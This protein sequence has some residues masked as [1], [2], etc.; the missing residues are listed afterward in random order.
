MKHI[1]NYNTEIHY[2]NKKSLNK[3]DY[4]NFYNDNFNF[5]KIED[6][7][8]SPQTCVTNNITN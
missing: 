5:S 4:Y 8:L 6:I 1:N 2:Y 7:S 3:K